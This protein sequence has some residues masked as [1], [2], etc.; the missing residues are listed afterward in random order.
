MKHYFLKKEDRTCG[1]CTACCLGWLSGKAYDKEFYPG[2]PCFY[3][4]K[5]GCSIYENRPHDPCVTYKCSW[6]LN[7]DEFPEWMQPNQSKVIPTTR[8]WFDVDGNENE[9]IEFIST[10]ELMSV[11]TYHWIMK[12]HFRTKVPVTVQVESDFGIYGPEDFVQFIL[13]QRN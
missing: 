2:N 10:G 6:I 1:D 7:P 11:T 5:T 8:S 12:F 3:V 9:Y 4:C 13:N